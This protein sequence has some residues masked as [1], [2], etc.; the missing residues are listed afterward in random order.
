MVCTESEQQFS[1]VCVFATSFNGIGAL[2]QILC[3]E[4]GDDDFQDF[5][6]LIKFISEIWDNF[7]NFEIFFCQ[8]S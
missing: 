5:E 3:F 4:H 7:D 6:E 1:V 8:T 2:A